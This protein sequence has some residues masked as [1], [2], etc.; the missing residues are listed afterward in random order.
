[1]IDE[2]YEQPVVVPQVMHLTRSF[3][4]VSDVQK[5]T[6]RHSPAALAATCVPS[7]TSEHGQKTDNQVP[8]RELLRARASTLRAHWRC[9]QPRTTLLGGRKC[10]INLERGW[11]QAAQHEL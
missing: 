1:M 5:D 8:H 10:E 2:R 3:H 9:H 6:F 4:D 11:A 7:T